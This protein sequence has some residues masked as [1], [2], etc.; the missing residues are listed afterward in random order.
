VSNW[1]GGHESSKNVSGLKVF[2]SIIDRLFETGR[3]VIDGF[4][5]N[6]TIKFDPFL[7]KWNYA[8]IPS[9]SVISGVIKS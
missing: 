9:V 4:K 8:A 5:E 1:Q 6:M 3:K 7:P 2:I